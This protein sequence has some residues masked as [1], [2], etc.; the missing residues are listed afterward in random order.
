MSPESCD[1]E[2]GDDDDLPPRADEDHG[3]HEREQSEDER[4]LGQRRPDGVPD[5]DPSGAL[6][7]G[8]DR[9]GDLRQVGSQR[10][11]DDTHQERRRSEP[12]GERPRVVDR[13]VAAPD[14]EG[15]TEE[16]ENDVVCGGHVAR[17]AAVRSP[18]VLASAVALERRSYRSRSAA[19][20]G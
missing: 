15:E 6:Q 13:H 19:R 11:E 4:V 10:D 3:G 8:G 17:T 2:G 14:G 20:D 16:H 5:V 7:V 1:R 9:V 12:C 18:P